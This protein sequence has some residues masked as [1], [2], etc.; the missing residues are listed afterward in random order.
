M[1][2]KE[3]LGKHPYSYQWVILC[4][5]LLTVGAYFSIESYNAYQTIS[6]REAERLTAQTK[7]VTENL[8]DQLDA[9]N[10]VL[11]NVRE[12]LPYLKN[13]PDGQTRIDM[14]LS[15]LERALPGVRTI[16]V[17]DSEGTI[18]A[19]NRKVLV[20]R[21]FRE[22]EYFQAAL[23][24]P[25]LDILYVSPP[26]LTSLD[27]FALNLVRAILGP[28]GQFA[29]IVAVTLSPEYF[30][31]L[32]YSVRYSPDVWTAL[33]HGDGKLFLF[34]PDRPGVRNME[35][36]V[37]GSFFSRH[38]ESGQNTSLFTGNVF[39]TKTDSMIALRTF[40]PAE[41]NMDKALVV[42]TSRD[43]R[44]I[45][46]PWHDKNIERFAVFALFGVISVFVVYYYQ[47]SQI[48]F[49][50][51][52]KAMEDT[53]R[54][55]G[56]RLRI[57]I[58]SLQDGFFLCDRDDRLV[59]INQAFRD[60]HPEQAQ[61]ALDRNLT[62]EELFRT[63]VVS[64]PQAREREEEFI[65]ERMEQHRNP[66]PPIVRQFNDG[67]WYTIKENRTSD[68]GIAGVLTNITKIKEIENALRE[69][70]AW[71]RTLTESIGA[72]PWEM[73][74]AT[75]R[76][77]YVGPQAKSMLGYPLA[78]W[79]GE[80]FWAAHLHQDDRV[81]AI[82]YCK[83]ATARGENHDFEY[84][85]LAADGRIVWLRDIVTVIMRDGVPNRLRGLMIDIT[86]RRRALE[87]LRS[88][89]ARLRALVENA[90]FLINIKDLEGRYLM[91]GSAWLKFWNF[92][93]EQALGKTT[94][95]LH[96]NDLAD[97]IAEHDKA[98]LATGKSS[99][100]EILQPVARGARLLS[101]TKFP[102]ND[103]QGRPIAI[104]AI[105]A[106]ITERR[107]IEEQLR[108]SLKMQAVGQLTAGVAH[109]FNNL[110]AITLGN[111][112]LA[113]EA[114][115]DGKV[116]ERI[117]AALRATNRGA[118]L[119]RQL[120]SFGRQTPLNP[121]IID[122]G[123][124]VR[125]LDSLLRRTLGEGIKI[126][127]ILA[128][129]IP[130]VMIDKIQIENA[131]INMALNARDAMPRGG[132]LTIETAT[133]E[134][135]EV[136]AESLGEDVKSGRYVMVAVSD[137]GAGMT[138]E[139]ANRAFEPF[140]TTKKV[141]SG[142]GLGLSMVY[143][144]VKQSGGFAKIYSEPGY[145]TSVKLYFPVVA[146]AG[147]TAVKLTCGEPSNRP[148]GYE[149]ILLI[150]DEKQVRDT[151]A[152]QLEFLGYEVLQAADGLE[153]IAFFKNGVEI[154]LVLSDVILAGP[155]TGPE[156][157]RKLRDLQPKLKVVFISGYPGG[158]GS[159]L[160]GEIIK[161]RLLQKPVRQDDL[162]RAIREEL[163]HENA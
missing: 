159:N 132:T 153:A 34:V 93:A 148:R 115:R 140:F 14:H 64:T 97:Q 96:P 92:T 120:L 143:G 131:L 74:L 35:L 17:T 54:Q 105:S 57:A 32:L 154:D 38:I 72:I 59:A 158:V 136:Q 156:I 116:L 46:A 155:L 77:T 16:F 40:K 88:S 58:D 157:V 7:I 87:A 138:P 68:G 84:R 18:T 13:L 125:D 160:H 39:I 119:T 55:R 8:T 149:R 146:D 118:T 23:R 75:W 29:G 133:T 10:S 30:E 11:E 152:A 162:A 98:V 53:I 123:V 99:T 56:Q 66:G 101:V 80:G 24:N 48:A 129:D 28:E 90:P 144:F 41:L 49:A 79:L 22:R 81:D 117:A 104:G 3:H 71:H 147:E 137:T 151:I 78:D 128:K 44:T 50:I 37:P 126:K 94:H 85:F 19:S 89:E 5:T 112:E 15:T 121:E 21:N 130:R 69:S 42:A 76:F 25:N 27:V 107:H 4:G 73:D 161:D 142:T 65:R 122:F 52:H 111:L 106:D 83:T 100:R 150:E 62:F 110:L 141:G 163:S 9:T 113:Q 2:F 60:I 43:L 51:A 1:S 103:E 45:L 109:D 95:Q 108:Q 33:I 61:K 124:L 36:A 70:E 82:A 31:T 127:P 20:G 86:D 102:I 139:V 63:L 67:S 26:F 134:L 135:D 12:Q 114:I 6:V 91:A 47:H 145:G